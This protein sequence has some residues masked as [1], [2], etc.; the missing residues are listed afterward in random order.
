MEPIKEPIYQVKLNTLKTCTLIDL[1]GGNKYNSYWVLQ[2]ENKEQWIIR[3]DIEK[4]F[5]ACKMGEKI[6]SSVF[7]K[8]DVSKLQRFLNFET[9]TFEGRV[10]T[11][12]C[13]KC[14]YKETNTNENLIIKTRNGCPECK[15]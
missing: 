1:G 8:K 4:G 10:L 6:D 12:T 5:Q 9:S 7:S 2:N 14:G 11:F 3:E 15:N 13:E